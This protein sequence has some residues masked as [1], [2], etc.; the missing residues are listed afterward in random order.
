MATFLT[1]TSTGAEV[2]YTELSSPRSKESLATLHLASFEPTEETDQSKAGYLHPT[3]LADVVLFLF[4]ALDQWPGII[5]LL[6]FT[7]DIFFHPAFSRSHTSQ[8]I[9]RVCVLFWSTSTIKNVEW[10]T[11]VLIFS[12]IHGTLADAGGIFERLKATRNLLTWLEKWLRVLRGNEPQLKL[13]GLTLH[14]GLYPSWWYPGLFP[15][16]DIN[17]IL[18]KQQ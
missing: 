15:Y 11:T 18:P 6:R 14:P 9:A 4:V 3:P 17:M 16:L 13:G 8:V 12:L 2:K 10:V 7:M 5:Y 1:W